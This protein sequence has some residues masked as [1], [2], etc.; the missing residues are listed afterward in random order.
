MTQASVVEH[1]GALWVAELQ[2]WG[3][4]IQGPTAGGAVEGD[5]A[6][7]ARRSKEFGLPHV[8]ITIREVWLP[9]PDPAGV[10]PVV[11]GCHLHAHSWHAQFD[12]A[13]GEM[14]AERLD[15]DRSKPRHLWLHRHPLGQP[16]EVKEPVGNRSLFEWLHE[17]ERLIYEAWLSD[18]K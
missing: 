14:A 10:S 13:G 2:D 9:G 3:Y 6:A 17:V 11:E 5:L 7:A 18:N 1:R 4:E 15:L 16:N 8:E 12:P